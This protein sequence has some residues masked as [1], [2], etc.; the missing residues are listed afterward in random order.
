MAYQVAMQSRTMREL[1]LMASSKASLL[2]SGQ[3]C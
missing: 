3:Q 2:D 1:A